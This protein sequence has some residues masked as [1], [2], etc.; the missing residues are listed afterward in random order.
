MYDGI[1]EASFWQ[2]LILNYVQFHKTEKKA[3]LLAQ[4]WLKQLS[5]SFHWLFT[6]GPVWPT[7]SHKVCQACLK[8]SYADEGIM[9]FGLDPKRYHVFLS[10]LYKTSIC[11]FVHG[12]VLVFILF[13]LFTPPHQISSCLSL[14]VRGQH[15]SFCRVLCPCFSVLFILFTFLCQSRKWLIFQDGNSYPAACF[16]SRKEN[17]TIFVA[18]SHLFVTSLFHK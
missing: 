14:L 10:F 12:L 1:R 5:Q 16:S 2:S 15:S 7:N 6:I 18:N 17:K 9:Q 3:C 11:L 4:I 13:T 8:T